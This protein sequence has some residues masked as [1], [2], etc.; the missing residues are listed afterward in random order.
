MKYEKRGMQGAVGTK[1]NLVTMV[2][3]KN[4]SQIASWHAK[5]YIR[6]T[7]VLW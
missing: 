6:G 5:E 4:Q 2:T 1:D 3:V 7:I